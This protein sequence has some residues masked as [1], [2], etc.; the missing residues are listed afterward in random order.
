MSVKDN[1][2]QFKLGKMVFG[3]QINDRFQTDEI[4]AILSYLAKPE[5]VDS[6]AVNILFRSLFL[7]L[8][9]KFI[10]ILI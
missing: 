3:L 10:P 2:V 4:N 8:Y 7:L 9:V 6:K 1:R 5:I